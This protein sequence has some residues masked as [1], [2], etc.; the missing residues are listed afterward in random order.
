MTLAA[1]K[2][3]WEKL[4]IFRLSA[5]DVVDINYINLWFPAGCG[6]D[7]QLRVF[8]N[9]AQVLPYP[10]SGV[11]TPSQGLFITGDDVTYRF[12]VNLR[13]KR[14]ETISVEYKNT[15]STD[16]YKVAVW[17]EATRRLG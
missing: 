13:L 17:L 15:N 3:S 14:G 1:N 6:D 9:S 12:K 4:N 5:S 16:S 2:T 10:S 8:C 7:I 11:A